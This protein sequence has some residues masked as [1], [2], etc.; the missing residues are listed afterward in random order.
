MLQTTLQSIL[1]SEYVKR[2]YGVLPIVTDPERY[3]REM[4]LAARGLDLMPMRLTGPVSGKSYLVRQPKCAF[5]AFNDIKHFSPFE[6]PMKRLRDLLGRNILT[7]DGQEWKDHRDAIEPALKRVKDFVFVMRRVINAK[8]DDWMNR[9]KQGRL[10][11]DMGSE[12]S[13]LTMSVLANCLLGDQI[14]EIDMKNITHGSVDGLAALFPQLMQ[15]FILPRWIPTSVNRRVEGARKK[16]SSVSERLIDYYRNHQE[17]PSNLIT[18]LLESK[19]SSGAIDANV[20]TMFIA[21]HE[22]TAVS[23]TWTAY[24]TAKNPECQEMFGDDTAVIWI[25]RETL[26]LDP[27]VWASGR[28]VKQKLKLG[29]TQLFPGD[30][31]HIP[32]LEIHRC[33]EWWGEDAKQYRPNRWC[34]FTASPGTWMPFGGGPRICAGAAFALTE[35]KDFLSLFRAR[36]GRFKLPSHHKDPVEALASFTRKTR[37]PLMIEIEFVN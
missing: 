28:Q 24:R 19:L 31:V 26:R 8:L 27:P 9:V 12:M 10:V 2:N 29:N 21:G 36:G 4:Y 1:W 23:L 3:F 14:T 33:E 11:V 37:Y 13:E 32:I 18:K 25:C 35:M 20:R 22:T 30:I 17:V 7:T 15:P 6:L 16:L 5:D 34:K